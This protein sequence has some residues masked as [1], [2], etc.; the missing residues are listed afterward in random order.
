MQRWILG[1]RVRA[2]REAQGLTQ[3]ELA[4][5]AGL[6]RVYLAQ[7]ELGIHR[8]QTLNTLHR[9]AKALGVPVTRLL[10]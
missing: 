8:N 2:L 10:E 3:A 7:L 4:T 9:L 6:H 5:R 1:E